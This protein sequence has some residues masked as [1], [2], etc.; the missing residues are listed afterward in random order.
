M[1]LNLTYGDLGDAC[2]AAHA[3]D[4]IGDRWSLIVVRELMFGP[5]TSP[6]LRSS[7][8]GV[9]PEELNDRLLFLERAGVVVETELGY[10]T[11]T[12]A[13]ALTD[14]GREL[15]A[16]LSA[17]SLWALEGSAHFPVPSTGMTPSGVMVAMRTMVPPRSLTTQDPV[18]V[19]WNLTDARC[20]D[21]APQQFRLD[22]TEFGF[23]LD[24]GDLP[25]VDVAVTGDSTTWAGVA[26]LEQPLDEALAKGDLQIDGDRTAL[27]RVI[28]VFLDAMAAVG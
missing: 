18:R 1:T 14:W 6:D 28:R 21:V 4:L 13:Y 9:G 16:V 23:D 20:P 2:A 3:L 5:R 25:R 26:L 19:R 24:V 22:W 7:L 12:T 11:K 8:I 27:E 15:E 17:L 10:L